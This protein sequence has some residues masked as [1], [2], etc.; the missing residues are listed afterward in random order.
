MNNEGKRK[1]HDK[2]ALL[3]K[4]RLN[5]IQ[6]SISKALIDSNII[7]DGFILISNVLKEFYDMKE[8]IKNPNDK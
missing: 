7:H 1:K 6:A 8:D 2:I 3:T 5:N 4:S